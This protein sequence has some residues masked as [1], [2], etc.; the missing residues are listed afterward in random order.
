MNQASGRRSRRLLSTLLTYLVILT[1]ITLPLIAVMAVI[2]PTP[3]MVQAATQQAGLSTWIATAA[4]QVL[5]VGQQIFGTPKRALAAT[6]PFV[7]DGTV[8]ITRVNATSTAVVTG[9]IVVNSDD[10]VSFVNLSPGGI[11]GVGHNGAGFRLQD[12]Y[13][14]AP[15]GTFL[16]RIYADGTSASTGVAATGNAGTVLPDGTY[17]YSDSGTVWKK[18][19]FNASG[20]PQAATNVTYSGVTLP[21]LYDLAAFP[22]TGEMYGVGN[23]TLYKFIYNAG[24]STITGSTVGAVTGLVAE[25]GGVFFFAAAF[26]TNQQLYGYTG[27]GRLYRVNV[28]TRVATLL[29]SGSTV[30]AADGA[31]CPWG[32]TFEKVLDTD[33]NTSGVQSA[34]SVPRGATVRYLFTVTNNELAGGQ[35]YTATFSDILNDVG[36]SGTANNGNFGK[37]IGSGVETASGGASAGSFS[38]ATDTV[39]DDTLNATLTLPPQSSITFYG[40]VLLSLTEPPGT[41]YNKAQLANLPATM[42]SNGILYSNDAA[43]NTTNDPTGLTFN[44]SVVAPEIAVTPATVSFGNQT[45]GTTSAAQTVTI[46]NTGLAALTI[47]NINLGGTNPSAFA[48]S[49]GT[50][51][52]TFP[53]NIAAGNSCTVDLVFSPTT[54]G[55]MSAVLMITNSDSDEGSVNIPLNGTGNAAAMPNLLASMSAP[56]TATQGTDFNYTIVISNTGS[57]ATSGVITVTDTL[58]AGLSFVSG[59]GSGFTCSAGGQTVTCTSSTVIAVNGT[60][61][62]NLTV[63][64][65]TTGVKSNMASVIG[66]G[67][68]SSATSNTVNTTVTAAATAPTIT[69]GGG[70]ANASVS[71]PENTTVVTTVTASGTAPITYSIVGGADAAKFTINAS[72]GVLSFVSAPDYEAPTDGGGNNVYDVTVRASNSAGTDDQ[73][74]AVTVT[75]VAEVAGIEYKLVY[76]GALNRYEVWMRSIGTPNAPKTTGTAQVTIK[77]PHLLGSGI[78]SPT[79]VTA[80]V[81]DTAW[82]VNSRTNGPA[83]DTS[84]DYISFALDFPTSNHSAINWQGGQEIL[85]FTFQN[86]GVCAGAVS[87][88]ENSDPFNA[89]PNNPGQQIDVF[90]LGSDP[91]DD[92]LGNYNLGQGDCDRDGDGVVNGSDLDDDGD[93][94]L[95]SVEGALTVDT[96]SD[97]IPD[98]LDLDSDGDGLPDNVEAQTTAGYVAP[99]GSDS[100]GDGLDNAYEGAGDAGLTPVN[101]DGADNPDYKDTDSDNA[102]GNDTT[103]ATLTKSNA[104]AD[105]DGL[106]DGIDSNDSAYGPVNAGVTN[107][108]TAYP[109][110]DSAGDVDYRDT[111]TTVA[112]VPLPIKVILGGAYQTGSGLMRDQLRR[113]PDFPLVSPYGDGATISNSSVLTANAIVD[114]VLVELRNAATPATVVASRG[115]LLQADGDVVGVDGV[116]VLSFS[117][118]ASNTV[119]VAVKHRNHLGVMTAAAVTLSPTTATV[120]FTAAGTAVY[121]SNAQR[122]LGGKQT[123]WPGNANGNTNVIGAGPSNDISTILGDVLSAPGN[124]TTNVNYILAGYRRTDLNLDGKTLAAGPNNDV[125]IVLTSVFVHPGN[126]ATAANYIVQQQL[127]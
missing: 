100:D 96:D 4:A 108:A 119:Y 15:D 64:P 46:N 45:S 113:L 87:L 70:G 41:V 51:G 127:P 90:G 58:P 62:I 73:A 95:D 111:A 5:Q 120:D 91:G 34:A 118:L 98:A 125:N 76:N 7:C 28:G 79:N 86:G 13:M 47:S 114:W 122:T 121:G 19:S 43:T 69:S 94:L 116:S 105:K 38:T 81:A 59:S 106:D 88:M 110:S 8:Y 39:T 11:N 89:A 3:Q 74:I 30:S 42:A 37:W 85:M 55:A 33:P 123:L 84:A 27:G 63:N 14:Y 54:A 92:F 16:R 44:N 99:S 25:S 124:Y 80:P 31:S 102:Q 82:A 77:A 18:I 83:A 17:L 22:T 97:G 67:D 93:G 117:G 10:T 109:N 6:D 32:P 49:G 48:V 71:I 115:A 104:D 2:Q 112:A 21:G 107:P 75:N 53:T 101:S 66:G 52:S 103:E 40:D 20:V 12:G 26:D 9:K 78:F 24:A 61:T 56:A 126:S 65:T 36:V 60:A 35:T 1:Q 68:T 23:G 50:C 57:A 72:T 29:G